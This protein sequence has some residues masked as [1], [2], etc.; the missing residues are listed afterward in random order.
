MARS[1]LALSIVL[2]ALQA[3]TCGS[4]DSELPPPAH[5][6]AAVQVDLS[7]PYEVA[8]KALD[9][10]RSRDLP[11]YSALLVTPPGPDENVFTRELAEDDAIQGLYFLDE[12]KTIAAIIR[13]AEGEVHAI[14]FRIVRTDD[15]FRVEQLMVTSET[16]PTDTPVEG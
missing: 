7:S 14:W 8:G 4:G 12:G 1:T 16:P 3:R 13:H 5:T 6:P 11:T 9:A 15:G 10:Y 2:I